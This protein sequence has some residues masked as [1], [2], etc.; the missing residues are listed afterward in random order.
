MTPLKFGKSTRY[1]DFT[2]N[3]DYG[4]TYSWDYCGLMNKEKI[5]TKLGEKIKVI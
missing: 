5:Q 2:I 3:N 1:L 4:S